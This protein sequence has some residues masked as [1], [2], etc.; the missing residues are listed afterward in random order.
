[1]QLTSGA[2]LRLNSAMSVTTF[3]QTWQT[4][5][6]TQVVVVL[7]ALPEIICTAFLIRLNCKG[8]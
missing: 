6:T 7:E 4:N 8:N 2:Y 5:S 1:M 3:A